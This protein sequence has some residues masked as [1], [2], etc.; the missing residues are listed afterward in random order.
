MTQPTGFPL[1]PLM[2]TADSFDDAARRRAVVGVLDSYHGTYDIPCEAIQNAVDAVEDAA[3]LDLG[4]PYRIDIGID[5][6]RNRMSFLD[7]GVGM[8]FAQV[9]RAF[10]PHVSFKVQSQAHRKRSNYKYLHRGFKGIGM[11]FLAYST[12]RIVIHSKKDGTLTKAKMQYGYS[13]AVGDRRESAQ[14]VN[15][16][17][18]S[19]LE[20]IDRGTYVEIEFSE[21]TRPKNLR[22]IALIPELWSAIFRTRTGIGQVLLEE[23]SPVVEVDV[24]LSVTNGSETTEGPVQ[25]TFLYPH[26]VRRSSVRFRFLNVGEYHRQN[27]EQSRIPMEHRRQDGIYVEWNCDRI[28][29]ELPDKIYKEFKDEIDKYNP[30]SYA[31]VPYQGGIWRE[32]NE[33]I[34]KRRSRK[35]IYPGLMIAVNRQRLADVFKI[36]PSRF[37][38]FGNNVFVVVHYYGAKPDHGRKTIDSESMG[39]AEKIGDR[40]IQYLAKQREFLRHS[41]EEEAPGQREAERNHDDWKFNVRTH[42]Q[43]SPLHIPPI[44]YQSTPLTEQDVVG[45]FNQLCAV[46]VFAGIKIYATSQSRTYD[47]LAE[48]DCDPNQRG[49][50]YSVSDGFLLGVSPS[51]LGRDRFRTRLVTIEFKNNLDALIAD[52]DEEDSRKQ[53]KHIDICVCWSRIESKFSGYIIDEIT[54][55]NVDRRKYP[56]CTHLL[57]R[58]GEAE[59]MGVIMLKPV[60]ELIQSSQIKIPL[61]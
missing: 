30:S 7:S 19:P 25:A 36:T 34:S 10:A 58:D 11:T 5:L 55:N 32:I 40:M 61:L 6:N 26:E 13:W 43:N 12:N 16:E 51:V 35:Y 20:A 59:A 15:D 31:F 48:Y 24:N 22:Y 8:D 45:L 39:L 44:C 29:K 4:G 52:I 2:A 28:I 41:G 38:T 14:L 3:L 23:Q 37:A 27:P 60:V 46:G 56:G 1:D 50:R 53:F 49:L 17:A 33:L 42:H 54:E 47:C 9:A 57:Y 21:I 18:S